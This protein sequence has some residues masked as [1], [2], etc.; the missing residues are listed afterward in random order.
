MVRPSQKDKWSQLNWEL[1]EKMSQFKYTY[2]ETWRLT[3]CGYK[4]LQRYMDREL[5]HPIKVSDE[6]LFDQ[7]LVDKVKF[8]YELRKQAKVPVDFSAV[9]YDMLKERCRRAPTYQ[10]LL[11]K[12]PEWALYEQDKK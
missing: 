5:V 3:G 4:T 12:M 2:E 6:W 7:N 1:R 8:I 11:D 9:L 10:D